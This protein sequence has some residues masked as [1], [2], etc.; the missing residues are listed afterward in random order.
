MIWVVV[1]LSMLNALFFALYR[2]ALGETNAV[3]SMYIL[4][5][6]DP[7][8]RGIQHGKLTEFLGSITARG[9]MEVAVQFNSAFDRMAAQL[10]KSANGSTL[11]SA[12]AVLWAAF[13]AVKVESNL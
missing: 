12:H 9:A 4:A 13:K 10:Y 8:F 11:L 5:I 7:E 1:I 3:R 2:K 6:L